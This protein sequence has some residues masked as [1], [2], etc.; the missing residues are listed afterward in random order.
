MRYS[1][2]FAAPPEDAP[3]A[4]DKQKQLE[5][6]LDLREQQESKAPPTQLPTALIPVVDLCNKLLA[7]YKVRASLLKIPQ[8]EDT[9]VDVAYEAII[10]SQAPPAV[11]N[12][13]FRSSLGWEFLKKPSLQEVLINYCKQ[14]FIGL[15][16]PQVERL[17]RAVG[18]FQ[19]T[20]VRPIDK[21]TF[22]PQQGIATADAIDWAKEVAQEVLARHSKLNIF[23]LS[24]LAT[25]AAEDVEDENLSEAELTKLLTILKAAGPAKWKA[26]LK[27]DIEAIKRQEYEFQSSM[28]AIQQSIQNLTKGLYKG[29][30]TPRYT[31]DGELTVLL[32]APYKL[33]FVF[34]RQA[35]GKLALKQLNILACL[36]T[37]TIMGKDLKNVSAAI[38]A[39]LAF[40]VGARQAVNKTDEEKD[41]WKKQAPLSKETQDIID[42]FIESQG[43]TVSSSLLQVLG[44]AIRKMVKV[45]FSPMTRK[46]V[47]NAIKRPKMGIDAFIRITEMLFD[48]VGIDLDRGQ[49]RQITS[50]LATDADDATLAASFQKLVRTL[51]KQNP[52]KARPKPKAKGKGEPAPAGA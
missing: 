35:G 44:S 6:F 37:H 26:S 22:L 43:P 48:E 49:L 47:A 2:R 28:P 18:F 30:I 45:E 40:G 36:S 5:T 34:D 19:H 10:S 15:G 25:A 24:A 21:R 1:P 12:F 23:D 41:S 11:V 31:D 16:L 4:P 8:F 33:L 29:K 39:V 3:Q 46:Y 52:P 9:G 32:N 51:L 14:N 13:A 38:D 20:Q 7:K 50:L 27:K 17:V 42:E